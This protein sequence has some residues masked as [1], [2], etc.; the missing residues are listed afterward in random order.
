MNGYLLDTNIVTAHL[1]G[2]SGVRQRIRDAELAGHSVRLNAV[3]YY[4]TKRGLLAI[5]AHRQL[6]AFEHLWRVLGMVMIDQAV[7]DKAAEL[8]AELRAR[9]QL[10]EDA[11]LLIA[12][13]ALIHDMTLVTHNTAHFVRIPS[14]QVDD[15]LMS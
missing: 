11:D 8:Y 3:S 12:A 13:M 5:G 4:E 7:L 14:L 9:G 2:H 1:K 15:W 6:A 10:I